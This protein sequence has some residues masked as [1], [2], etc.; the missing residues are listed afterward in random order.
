[1]Q[2]AAHSPQS[3][4]QPIADA[5][6]PAKPRVTPRKSLGQ[7][8]LVDR[9]ALARI[10]D[11][12]AIEP[13][14]VVVEVGPGTGLLTRPLAERAARVVAVEMDAALADR[15]RSDLA[16]LTNL[17]VVHADA[18]E[19]DPASVGSPYKLVANLPYYAAAPIVRRFLECSRPPR[20]MV[21]TVQREVG[22]SMAARPGR[23]RTLSVA[24]QLYGLPRIVG[25]VRPGSFRPPPK[26][27]SAIVRVDVLDR[28]ALAL[29]D[30]AAFFR[31]VHAG[32]GEA[33]KQLR[34]SLGRALGMTGPEVEAVMAEAGVDHRLRAE[35]LGLPEWGR[36]YDAFRSR[37]LC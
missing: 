2:P 10:V 4:P 12:A 18:R 29:D 19:W 5:S 17:E 15:L 23:M 28:P 9:G 22:Q 27:T 20:L 6:G 33:R 14:D 31:L 37:G 16:A 26:V 25:Y 11:A 30:T 8:F 21:V 13:H 1:M 36:L 3:M 34:N 7:H 32:F 35:A 24:T